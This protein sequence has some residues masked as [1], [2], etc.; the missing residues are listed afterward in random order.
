MPTLRLEPLNAS[1]I[2]AANSLTLKPG[3]EHYA[4]PAS[5]APAEHNLNP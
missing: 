4:T 2:V 1:N 3:Q 5:Y